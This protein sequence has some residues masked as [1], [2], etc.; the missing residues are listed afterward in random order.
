MVQMVNKI[1]L[2]LTT[3]GPLKS[4]TPDDPN[5]VITRFDP[6]SSLASL[7]AT[8]LPLPPSTGKRSTVLPSVPEDPLFMSRFATWP[9]GVV[10]RNRLTSPRS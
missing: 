1:S 7:T 3:K 5:V 10:G 9:L 2:W 8:S 4:S 6:D